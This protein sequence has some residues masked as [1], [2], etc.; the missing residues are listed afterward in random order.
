MDD[1]YHIGYSS[2]KSD[3]QDLTKVDFI[4][5][6]KDGVFNP[7]LIKNEY[8]EGTGHQS[9]I[10]YEGQYYAVYHGRDISENVGRMELDNE[11]R[12]ARICKLFF[13]NEKIR[14][15]RIE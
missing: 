9:V 2:A 11:K 4:K 8:E 13:E 7:V 14:A 12:T 5:H 10:Y 6:T 1:T 15:E 3:E